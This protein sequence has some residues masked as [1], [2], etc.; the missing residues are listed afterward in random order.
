[1][2]YQVLKQ[3][4]QVAESLEYARL[5]TYLLDIT[6][7]FAVQERPLVLVC[8]GGGYHFTSEREA[9]IVAMQFNAMG[10]HSAV[11]DYSC[12]PAQFPTALLELSKS[13]AYLRAHAK[14]WCIDPDKIAVLGFSA[15][16]HLAASLG[17]FWNTEWFARIREES[18]AHAAAEATA[19]HAAAEATTA[20]P[21]DWNSA[22]QY[23][24]CATAAATTA[25]TAAL[26]ADQIKPNRI[27]LAYPVITTEEHAHRESINNLLGEARCSDSAWLEKMSLEKQDLSDFPPAFI[28]HTSYDGSVPIENSLFLVAALAKYRKPLEYHVFPGNVHGMSLANWRTRSLERPMDTPA[29]KWIELVHT[30][31]ENWREA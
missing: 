26:T 8:P 31:L 6:P 22:V 28:W 25:L 27:I 2:N 23:A 18:A 10:Y 20:Q 29:K 16:G 14:E 9:E 1:M 19:A 5:T 13:V 24:D 7:K 21:A 15:G 3:E 4:I 17:V 30:W 12:A 11:L